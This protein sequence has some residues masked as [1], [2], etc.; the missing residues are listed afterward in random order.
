MQFKD[1][2]YE[3]LREAGKP[4]HY[5][6]ITDLAKQKGILDTEGQ[7]PHA[8]MGAL[9]YTDTLNDDSRFQ[10][11]G[12]GK[13]TLKSSA[14][15]G[16]AHQIKTAELTTRQELRNRLLQMHPQKFEELI[17]ALLEVMG[18][19]ETE[20]TPYV[21]DRGIDVKGIL[22]TNQLTPVRVVIQAKRWKGNVGSKEV[23]ELRGSLNATGE[24]G[25][26]ITVKDFTQDAKMD[27]QVENRIPITL[28]NGDKLVG[29]LFDYKLGIKEEQHT[30]RSIDAEY[31]RETFG[32]NFEEPIRPEVKKSKKTEI[33]FPVVIRA[34][35]KGETF[36]GELLDLEGNVRWNG[37]IYETPST[38]AR[39]ITTTW[40]GVNGWKLWQY[41]NP[42]SGKWEKIDFLRKH[43]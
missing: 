19:E 31:W 8:T 7:T 20:T 30:V 13:F 12:K 16:I 23:R 3:V 39:M 17:R 18:F 28:I 33:V 1:A 43:S 25:I 21:H 5:N 11:E 29:L 42:K 35:H 34:Q 41:Q 26:M 9:L 14:I 2:A 32:V 36:M 4:L 40:K 15:T 6:E 22:R 27:A 37:Q 10:R 24:Q 38:A